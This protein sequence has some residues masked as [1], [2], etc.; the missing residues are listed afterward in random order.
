MSDNNKTLAIFITSYNYGEFI[1]TAIESVINQSNPNWKLYIFDN[2]STDNTEQIVK[3]YLQKDNRISWK[4]RPTNIGALNN[5]IEGFR[6]V[7]A[8]YI[9]L[10]TADDWLMPNV[11]ADAFS[12]FSEMQMQSKNIPFVAFGSQAAYQDENDNNKFS[13]ARTWVPFPDNFKGQVFLTPTLTMGNFISMD[14]LFFNK[15][16]LLPFLDDL[17]NV[18]LRQNAECFLIHRLEA[19]YGAGFFYAKSSSFFRRH[20]QQTT[21]KNT[22]NFQ[23]KIESVMLPLLDCKGDFAWSETQDNQKILLCHRFL[24][25]CIFLAESTGMTFRQSAEYLLS[26]LG[27]TF[28][29][30]LANLDINFVRE[31]QLEKYLLA[32]AMAIHLALIF[33]AKR[34][35]LGQDLAYSLEQ[36]SAWIADLQ[37]QYNF[38][39]VA[40]MLDGINSTFYQ[41]QNLGVFLPKDLIKKLVA[42]IQKIQGFSG[43]AMAKFVEHKFDKS[44]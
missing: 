3:K 32:A 27:K 30:Q 23:H 12:A 13:L 17:Q 1:G 41:N 11:V 29:Q 10:L 25:M 9:S 44:K 2:C 26:D 14:T 24:N 38:K 18:N 34:P 35:S 42:G 43:K 36:L 40:E 5:I 22:Q 39:N 31:N 37:K 15:K 6:E 28:A 33:F 21:A 7:D 8:D 20:N 19:A 16:F 4:K